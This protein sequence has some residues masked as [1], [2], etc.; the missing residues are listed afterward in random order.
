MDQPDRQQA[1]QRQQQNGAGGHL[2]AHFWQAPGVH[3]VKG[4][5]DAT[6]EDRQLADHRL[7]E[8]AQRIDTDQHDDAEKRQGDADRFAKGELFVM[9]HQMRQ[10]DDEDRNDRHQDG[11]QIGGR[12]LLAPADQEEGQR[13][14]DHAEQDQPPPDR[15]AA[16]PG[17]FAGNGQ[18]QQDRRTNADPHRGEAHRWQSM[19]DGD[20][21]G[22]EGRAPEHRQNQQQAKLDRAGMADGR[23]I[24]HA[25]ILAALLADGSGVRRDAGG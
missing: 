1:D 17:L 23:Q 15:L 11:C 3:A 2:R 18:P 4:I 24:G 16:R 7:P 21:D 19:I 20:L 25:V 22:D 5:A 14:T 6:T 13:I 12:V 9:G 8:A 10:D